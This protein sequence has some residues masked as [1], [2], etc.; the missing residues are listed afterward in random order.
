MLFK[1]L[2]TAVDG[3]GN[4]GRKE[5]VAP[6]TPALA[7]PRGAAWLLDGPRSV[8]QPN[9]ER[10]PV[11]GVAGKFTARPSAAQP[12]GWLCA[13]KAQLA[14]IARLLVGYG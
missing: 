14:P 9:P 1:S 2:A 5:L 8:T 10:S 3:A 6:A 11:E 12:T 7:E 13:G 4:K